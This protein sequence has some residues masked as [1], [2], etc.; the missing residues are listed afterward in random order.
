MDGA[1]GGVNSGI[2]DEGAT[3][4]AQVAAP[5][6]ADGAAAAEG[7]VVLEKAIDGRQGAAVL[8]ADAAALALGAATLDGQPLELE[9]REI[10]DVK[11]LVAAK[12]VNHDLVMARALDG[13]IGQDVQVAAGE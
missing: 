3:V 10:A 13:H 4:H 5:F 7:L 12:G 11:D 9:V 2:P 8:N 1:A 6:E